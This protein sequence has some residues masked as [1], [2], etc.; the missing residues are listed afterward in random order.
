MALVESTSCCGSG[1]VLDATVTIKRLNDAHPPK[2]SSSHDGVRLRFLIITALGA[3][4]ACS[5]ESPP[6]RT[7]P[8]KLLAPQ[9]R[10]LLSGMVL[11]DE[12]RKG[13][14]VLY[15]RHF[16]TDHTKWHEDPIKPKHGEMS[17]QAFRESCDQQRPLTTFGRRRAADI[18]KLMKKQ[19]IPIGRVLSSPYCRAVESSTLLAGREPDETPYELVHRGG[20]LT[21]EMMAANIRPY[22]GTPPAPGT[23]TLLVAHRPQMDD[24]G[25]IEEGQAFVL[26]PLG[27][28]QFNLAGKIYDSDWYEAE[29]NLDY[30]GLRGMQ[31]AADEV[32]RG[33]A[34]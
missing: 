11:R 22:L 30:L 3:L 14:Y 23:N 21:Y 10:T 34:R 17:V 9:E 8:P 2:A 33:V 6:P 32:P 18:G 28:G 20:T 13:G 25:F 31:A 19:G 27:N 12:L 29:F 7:E 16:H 24:V 15:F 26:E 1:V 5:S 4:C